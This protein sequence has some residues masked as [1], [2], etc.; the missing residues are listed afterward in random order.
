MP[1]LGM[2]QGP[3]NWVCPITSK[4]RELRGRTLALP[5]PWDVRGTRGSPRPRNLPQVHAKPVVEVG[6][7]MVLLAASFA[8][9]SN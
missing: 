6:A 1:A 8:A 5:V 9:V 7:Q 2:R 4:R 3:Q